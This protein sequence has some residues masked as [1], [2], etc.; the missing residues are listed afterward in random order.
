MKRLVLIAAVAGL[1]T[2]ASAADMM[3]RKAPPPPPPV[4]VSNWDVAFGAAIMS[5]YN[6]RGISQSARKPGVAA[7]FEPRYNINPNLQLYAGLAGA[8]IDYPNHAAA[9]IDIYAGIRPTFGKLALDFGFWFYD[10]PGGI[11]FDGLTG[12]T[13]CTNLFITPTGGCNVLKSNVSFWE[14]YAKATYTFTDAFSVGANLF[15][16]PDWLN[17]SASGTYVSG[18]AKFTFPGTI[19]PIGI[20]AF[21]SAELGHYFLGTTDPFYAVPL[22]PA[23]VP[24]PD[25][26]T[27]NIGLGLTYKVFT[28]DLR[29]YDTDLSKAKCNVLTGDHTATFNPGAVTAINASG[30]ESKWCGAAFIAKLSVDTTLSALK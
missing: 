27:W 12:A 15:Y 30:L 20:G 1:S 5:D 8:S 22:F 14:L 3:V 6:F 29:Y 24:L 16:S 11:R 21:V 2:A 7:Y 18:T 19:L 25:Y 28:L 26:T 4:V 9:E 17:T 13:S 23:G 10:Y